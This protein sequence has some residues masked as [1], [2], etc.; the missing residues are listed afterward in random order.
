MAVW[1]RY[2]GRLRRKASQH[3]TDSP[4]CTKLLLEKGANPN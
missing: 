1:G 4:E 2:G 3:P